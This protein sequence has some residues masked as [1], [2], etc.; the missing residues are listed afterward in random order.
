MFM[1]HR[2]LQSRSREQSFL[3]TVR[4]HCN[5]VDLVLALVQQQHHHDKMTLATCLDEHVSQYNQLL[6]TNFN[7]ASDRDRGEPNI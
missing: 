5:H 6:E 3:L 4:V 7:V 2:T 1:I